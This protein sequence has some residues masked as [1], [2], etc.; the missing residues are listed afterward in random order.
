MRAHSPDCQGGCKGARRFGRSRASERGAGGEAGT[1]KSMR[2]R[3][4]AVS[5]GITSLLGV[6]SSLLARREERGGGERWRSVVTSVPL[7]RLAPTWLLVASDNSTTASDCIRRFETAL[8]GVFAV[9]FVLIT[10]P[11]PPRPFKLRLR[12]LT[13][14]VT[15]EVRLDILYGRPGNADSC[16]G[17]TGLATARAPS[18]RG[19]LEPADAEKPSE[20]KS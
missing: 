17:G 9:V 11:S 16:P 7:T 4:G 1:G 3:E 10:H 14:R 20:S 12:S 6:N 18:R 15:V 19:S 5:D 8:S 13:T 2:L